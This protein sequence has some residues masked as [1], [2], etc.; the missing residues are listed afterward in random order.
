VGAWNALTPTSYSFFGFT[1]RRPV[2]GALNPRNEFADA[3]KKWRHKK[4]PLLVPLR[5]P[6]TPLKN[7]ITVRTNN[8]QS[9]VV[10]WLGVLSLSINE[11]EIWSGLNS[12]LDLTAHPN[13]NG[14]I[15][16]TPQTVKE[17]GMLGKLPAGF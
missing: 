9:Q 2:L 17:C 16:G 15:W 4:R 8:P 6:L 3:P 13:R 10:L 12:A 5:R 14:F 7:R 1:A 11:S